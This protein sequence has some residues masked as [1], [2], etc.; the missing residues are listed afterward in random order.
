MNNR[1]V[2]MLL[3]C[4]FVL[5][6]LLRFTSLSDYPVGFHID[7]ASLG[8]NGYSLL[9][10]GKDENNHRFPL[11]VD[12]F[13]D[14][15]PSGYH[16]LTVLPVAVFGLNE[17]ATRFPGALFGSLTVFAM[18]F[19]VYTIFKEK[20]IA[21]LATL[22]LTISPWHVGLSRASAEAVVA[23]FFI[24]IGF[25]SIIRS[26]TSKNALWL[27]P[28]SICVSFSFFFYHTPRVFVP[29]LL[30]SLALM[31]IRTWTSYGKKYIAA[32]V[33]AVILPCL[34]ALFLVFLI[35]GGTGRF[36]QVNIFTF[37][38]T[39][40]V[41]EEQIREDGTLGIPAK[42]TR[43]IHN[44]ISNYGQTFVTNYFEYFTGQFLFLKGGKPVWYQI[45][46]MGLLY[47]IELP[48]IIAGFVYLM[49][50]KKILAF[51]PLVW[52]LVAPMTA[53]IT[54][55]DV[56]NINRVIVL[57]PIFEIYA[58]VGFFALLDA[59]PKRYK[60]GGVA[61][62]VF[63]LLI[64]T[65]YFYHQYVV[66]GKTHTTQFRFNGFKELVLTLNAENPTSYDSII[67]TKTQGGIYPHFLFFTKYDPATYQ[68]DG[69]QKDKNYQGFG[70]Y[71]FVPQYCP[72]V[73][74][75]DHFP[76]VKRPIFVD[77]GSCKVNP[78]YKS[79][80]I[81]REDGTKAFTIVYPEIIA[82]AATPSGEPV[83]LH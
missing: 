5:A 37:P 26:I 27:I 57:F 1:L 51:V 56:P 6:V 20:R 67:V 3:G 48:F 80:A 23:L 15:R 39:R 30:L 24:F 59:I 45:P 74:K 41:L 14:N 81:Y 43:M 46:N 2:A 61:L 22:L 50:Q 55:D 76:K 13:G 9:K 10:T 63:A 12:M 77:H 7:E 8:Y 34:L 4:M 72:S 82:P 83:I 79:K 78:L 31:F 47:L 64:N 70:P 11:Y 69:S 25:G 19:L 28:G 73:D 17:F 33:A 16:Y 35:K 38:E 18:F 60:L 40:L 52:M 42:V 58:T 49:S 66:H 21:L 44:K 29:L 75:D 53:S 32:F 62:V 65:G 54:T 36:S 71:I 68:K